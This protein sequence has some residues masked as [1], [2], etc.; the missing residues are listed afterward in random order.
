MCIFHFEKLNGR[1]KWLFN[2]Q[3]QKREANRRVI[4]WGGKFVLGRPEQMVMFFI[5]RKRE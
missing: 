3:A 2:V 4:R 5:P 1:I